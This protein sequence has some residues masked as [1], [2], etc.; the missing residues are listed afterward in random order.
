[1]GVT[2]RQL[3]FMEVTQQMAF[4]LKLEEQFK[5]TTAPTLVIRNSRSDKIR[6]LV[7]NTQITAANILNI[8]KEL[9]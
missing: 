2:Y 5:V 1:L 7:G 9:E 3:S 6:S 4:F 8:V